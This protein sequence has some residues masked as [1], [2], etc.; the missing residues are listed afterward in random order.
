MDKGYHR[1][2]VFNVNER[3]LESTESMNLSLY[4]DF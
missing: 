1:D 4:A 3:V 2:P